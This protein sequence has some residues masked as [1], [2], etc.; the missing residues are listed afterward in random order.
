MNSFDKKIQTRLRM[1]PEMLRH[2]LTEP[3]EETLTTLTRY[4]LFE[5]KGAYLGQLLLSLLPQWEY[6][7]CEGNAHLGQIIRNLEKT[8]ISPVAQESDFLRANLLRIRI[9]A[10]TPGVFPFSPLIIQEHLLNFLEGADLIADL[11]QLTV[12]NFSRDE[13]RPLASELAQYRLS[14]L[15][16]RY[17]QNLFHQERQEAI[18]ANLAYLCKNYPLLGTC[19]QAYALLLSL[20]NIENWSK[21]PF[22]LRLVSNRFWDYRTKEIL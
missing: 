15:S 17:V 11:P 13:L 22:C 18:L 5:S 3:N 4:K 8:P 9:L 12:I 2:I 16:R 21:H 6:L 1:H 20:D 7:A 10:E 19:R 14:P